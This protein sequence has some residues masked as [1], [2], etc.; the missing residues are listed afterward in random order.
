MS[1]IA[2]GV[3]VGAAAGLAGDWMKSDAMGDAA[4]SQSAAA[5]YA[6]DE[7]KRQYDQ[8][9]SD[10]EPWRQAGQGAL[11]QLGN[12]DFNRDFTAND[13][14]EDPGYQFRMQE[15][16]RALERS[17]SARGRLNSGGT[18]RAIE[19]YG[20]DN[21]SGEYQN[22]YNRFNQDRDRRFSRLSAVAGLGQTA[23]AQ[24]DQAGQH[25]TDAAGNNA[26]GAANAQGASDVAQ[27]GVWSGT[28]NNL[29]KTWM[30]YTMMNKYNPTGGSSGT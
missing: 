14:Q 24:N 19:R 11:S 21:A 18:M 25:Y 9:R 29:G 28:L 7:Q 15:G 13:F 2:V 3:G 23:N 26:M 1:F 10:R 12:P 20:Q 8:S 5:R 22:A 27:A 17:A 6:T 30:D 4:D 16:Q